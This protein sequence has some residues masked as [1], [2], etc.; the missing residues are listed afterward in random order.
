MF[1][2]QLNNAVENGCWFKKESLFSFADQLYCCIVIK[3][4]LHGRFWLVIARWA[5]SI[6][7]PR[8][9]Y[10]FAYLAGSLAGITEHLS[11]IPVDNVKT[12]CQ[13]THNISTLKIIRKI[14]QAGGLSNFYSGSSAVVAGCIPAHAIYFSIYEKAK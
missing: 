14:Y 4:A 10:L 9:R 8:G 1:F 7:C 3:F 2:C 13:A 5:D 6:L 12:H 11:M